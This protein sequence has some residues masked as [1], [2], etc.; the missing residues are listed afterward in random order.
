MSETAI[1][2][3]IVARVKKLL[4]LAGN[5]SNEHEA[6]AAAEKA[7][8]LMVEYNLELAEG[9]ETGAAEA[10]RAKADPRLEAR[11]EWQVT[12]MRN[13]AA[14]NFCMHWT[15]ERRDVNA[16]G[17]GQVRNRTWHMLIGRKANVEMT[18]SMYRYL[19]DAMARLN[20]Y[21][22]G[23]DRSHISWFAGCADRLASRLATLRREAEAASRARRGETPRGNG[24]DLVLSDVYSSED[25]L[26]RDMRYGY[27]PGTTARQRAEYEAQFAAREAARKAAPPGPCGRE[28]R[29]TCRARASRAGGGACQCAGE[30]LLAEDRGENR[31]VGVQPRVAGGARHRPGSAGPGGRGDGTYRLVYLGRNT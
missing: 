29:D 10:D 22:D 7:Q 30:P 21:Q 18:L 1:P 12:I 28:A 14:N 17:K 2:A 9:G 15:V 11:R 5:N 4:A 20:P 8:A 13:L 6:S 24:T 16:S 27:D 23:R 25:D 3:S 31:P 26:N 19:T